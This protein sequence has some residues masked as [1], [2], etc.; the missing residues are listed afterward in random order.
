MVTELQRLVQTGHFGKTAAEAAE[1]IIAAYLHETFG[2]NAA[3]TVSR[4]TKR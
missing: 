2:L 1:R 3:D 4:A